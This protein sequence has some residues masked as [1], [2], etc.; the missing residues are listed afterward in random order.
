[1]AASACPP[2]L[3]PLLHERRLPRMPA[4]GIQIR[5]GIRGT[6]RLRRCYRSI[7]ERSGIGVQPQSEVPHDQVSCSARDFRA[8][9]SVRDC[10]AD[11]CSRREGKRDGGPG[12]GQPACHPTRRSKLLRPGLAGFRYVL[13]ARGRL[14]RRASGSSSGDSASL[15]SQFQ[16]SHHID[17]GASHS[18]NVGIKRHEQAYVPGVVLDLIFARITRVEVEA[19]VKFTIL[20]FI[21]RFGAR[22][23]A[24]S[25]V[26]RAS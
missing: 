25:I 15:I 23:A 1:M 21:V 11:V 6:W 19:I 17:I 2:T 14:G 4:R 5:A 12:Q 13:P 8:P 16:H 22:R 10:P 7:P 18:A 9:R 26:S 3:G 24:P 20:V